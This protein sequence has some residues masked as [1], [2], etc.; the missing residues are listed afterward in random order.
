VACCT[1]NVTHSYLYLH[2]FSDRISLYEINIIP[3]PVASANCKSCRTVERA[4]QYLTA[5]Y[6]IRFRLVLAVFVLGAKL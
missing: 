6:D 3:Y 1:V 2:S 4:F 5:K